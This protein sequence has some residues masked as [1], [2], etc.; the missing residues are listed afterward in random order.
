MRYL[1]AFLLLILSIPSHAVQL[2]GLYSA[3][4]VVA[5]QSQAVRNAAMNE[6]LK[7]VV[8]KVSGRRQELDNPSLQA[9]LSNVGS[10]VEQF[11]YKTLEEET[12]SYRLTIS[13][14]K[15]ALDNVLQQF[16]VP[17]WGKNRPEILLWLAVDDGVRR[18]ILADEQV[19]ESVLSAAAD[20]GLPITLPLFDLDDQRALSFN[21]VWAGFSDQVLNAS[22]R[23]S[24]KH[25]VHGRLLKVSANEWRLSGQL[26]NGRKQDSML[27]QQGNMDNVLT[28]FLAETVEHLADVYAPRGTVQQRQIKIHIS[29]IKD[30]AKLAEVTDYLSSLDRVKTVAWEALQGTKL[31]LLLSI[32]GEIAVLQDIIAL[33]KVLSPVEPPLFYS[34]QVLQ[35]VTAVADF[36]LNESTVQGEVP[37]PVID[38]LYYRAN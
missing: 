31:E 28:R 34:E 1:I 10:Y 6:V 22:Q 26:L 4:V 38:V 32:S 3:S 19:A 15:S 33:N 23:Y 12:A 8:Q 7:K 20:S 36:A 9:A 2:E 24:V 13:F 17:I 18:Y 27:L 30:L 14:Q 5:D 16:S 25:V 37:A 29:G 11:Q 35:P 21:D